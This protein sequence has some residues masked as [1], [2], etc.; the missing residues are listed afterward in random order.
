MTVAFAGEKGAFGELAA[1]EFFGRSRRL[2]AVPEFRDVFRGVARGIY[3]AGV[4]PVE[5]SLAGSIH[6]N[7]DLLL[8]HKLYIVGELP[9]RVRHFLIGNK[10][11][12]RSAVR[13][14]YSHL[15]AFAQCDKFLKR[16]P[17]ITLIPVSNT[18]AAVK[19]IRDERLTDAA[20]IASCQAA[21]D[22]NMKVLARNIED[23][24]CNTTRFL[25][26]S[27]KERLPATGAKQVKSTVVFS[28][29]NIP[30]ALYKALGGFAQNNI[31][32]YKIESRPVHGR[33]FSYLFYLDFA[34]DVRSDASRN[35]IGH[36]Q[37][38]TSDYRFL[39]S[40]RV[41]EPR[42]PRCRKR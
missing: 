24:G 8:E 18:A 36:L 33:G 34:G 39:G 41:E 25:V 22:F 30:G 42:D 3:S 20:A 38:I 15:A 6:Q 29:K 26:V 23:T 37:E 12:S 1:R 11:T 35:A 5:N 7:Y 2:A 27:K 32:L 10:G 40:Y 17:H 28:V 14:L 9:L 31:N 21:I 4:V 13:R 19:K 16:F